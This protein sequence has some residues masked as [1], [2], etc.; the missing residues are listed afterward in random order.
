MSQT[1]QAI[2][3][4]PGFKRASDH[5]RADHNRMVDEIVELTQIAGPPFKEQERALA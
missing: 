5:L 3:D 1:L 2:K 4:H